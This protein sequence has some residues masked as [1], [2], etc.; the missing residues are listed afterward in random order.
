MNYQLC[1]GSSELGFHFWSI[2]WV[3]PVVSKGRRRESVAEEEG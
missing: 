3:S 2:F 1:L